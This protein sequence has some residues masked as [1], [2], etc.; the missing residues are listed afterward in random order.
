MDLVSLRYFVEVVRRRSVSKAAVSLGTVQPALTRRIKL[1]EEHLNVE[2]LTRHR[3]G[4]E[5]T[6]AGV[7]VLERAETILRLA[8]QLEAEARS[9][10]L[11]TVGQARFAFPPSVGI[12]FVGKL[13]SDC[14]A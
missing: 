13:L 2:L 10:G 4:V 7:L 3:R 14:V 8:Q 12:L 5:P 9:H 6:E 1:L 11:E